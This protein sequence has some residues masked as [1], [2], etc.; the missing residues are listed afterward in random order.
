MWPNKDDSGWF[1]SFAGP[2]TC[3]VTNPSGY[4]GQVEVRITARSSKVY[5]QGEIILI[6]PTRF[7]SSK[8]HKLVKSGGHWV[9]R[10]IKESA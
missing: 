6:Q 9:Y 4:N 10:W 3:K 2:I 8:T 7:V 1:D 5:K